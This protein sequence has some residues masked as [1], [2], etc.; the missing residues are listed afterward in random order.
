LKVTLSGALP[1]AGDGVVVSAAT[2]ATFA[3]T[4]T[5]S[6]SLAPSLSV[7]VKVAVYDP[8]AYECV[9]VFAG[10]APLPLAA[11]LPSP[12]LSDHAKIVPSESELVE[13][14]NVTLR[15]ASPVAGAGDEVRCAVGGAFTST[16]A[17]S[18]S[19][20]PLLSVTVRT[21]E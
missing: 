12:K 2:G 8:A 4:A 14:W 19:V 16:A 13:P 20:A 9:A 1:V 6:V 10:G 5:E 15:G 11:A 18:V 17:E 3:L 7:T 21:A